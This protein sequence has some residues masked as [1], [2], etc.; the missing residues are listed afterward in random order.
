[1]VAFVLISGPAD[2]RRGG[3]EK[4]EDLAREVFRLFG[5]LAHWVWAPAAAGTAASAHVLGLPGRSAAWW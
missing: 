1:M 3:A 5:E 2:R 4:P